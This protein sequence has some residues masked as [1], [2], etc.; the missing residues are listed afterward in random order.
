MFQPIY[1][2][3]FRTAVYEVMQEANFSLFDHVVLNMMMR[4]QVTWSN[5]KNHDNLI[6]T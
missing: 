2:I 4:D 1:Q 6:T 5:N 3:S